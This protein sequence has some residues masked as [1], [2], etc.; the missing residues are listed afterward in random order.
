M[1]RMIS[2]TT[3]DTALLDTNV[4]NEITGEPQFPVQ[5]T[6]GVTSTK[7]AGIVKVVNRFIKLLYTLKGTNFLDKSEGTYF[8]NLFTLNVQDE[9]LAQSRV[10]DAVDDA[11]NQII[12]VQS[13]QGVPVNEKLRSATLTQFTVSETREVL[14]GVSLLFIG[15]NQTTVQLPSVTLDI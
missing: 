7:V 15:G 6:L 5:P 1:A 12:K 11:T 13:L 4:F 3:T 9:E 10:Q 8:T 2:P 14:M